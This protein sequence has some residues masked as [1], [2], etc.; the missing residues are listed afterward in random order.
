V[1]DEAVEVDGW[2]WR[3]SE[4]FTGRGNSALAL[5]AP[6]NADDLD[7]R[8]ATVGAWYRE[9]DLPP[10]VAVP[11]PVLAG[12]HDDLADRGWTMH[13][14]GRVLVRDLVE[15]VS[16]PDAAPVTITVEPDED[17]LSRYHDRGGVLPDVG[18]RMLTRGDRVGLASVRDGGEVVAIGRGAL[19]DGWLGVNAVE[20][21]PSHRRRGLAGDVLTAL[22]DWARS[23]GATAGFLQ[24]DLSNEA[25]RRLYERAGF[26]EHH[27][28]HYL[29]APSS[30]VAR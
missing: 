28:Y 4:G 16:R 24:V 22:A 9:R 1:P 13:H 11:L 19:T 5:A 12:L 26:V 29:A 23:H 21:V 15:L 2:L 6:S 14:G 18:R 10:W 17:W 7:Q 20:T 25:A 8:L 27:T 30:G 3:A